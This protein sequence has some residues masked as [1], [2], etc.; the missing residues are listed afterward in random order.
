MLY[1]AGRHVAAN[2]PNWDYFQTQVYYDPARREP[3]PAAAKVANLFGTD[4]V[5][6]GVPPKSALANGAMLTVV[7]GQTFHGTLA[8]APVDKT[9]LRQ[10][11]RP[12]RRARD[13]SIALLRDAQRRR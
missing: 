13:A 11:P 9:P 4:D 5:V 10:Q 3:R 1:A 7:V 12:S 2:A 8:P 6:D